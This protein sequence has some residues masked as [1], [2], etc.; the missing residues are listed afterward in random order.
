MTD[1]PNNVMLQITFTNHD[2]AAIA[3]EVEVPLDVAMERAWEWLSHIGDTATSLINE[4]L[5]SAIKSG[6][7]YRHPKMWQRYDETG[8]DDAVEHFAARLQAVLKEDS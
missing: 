6:Q 3:E 1:G 5:T 2:V 8:I 4:Q 7:P